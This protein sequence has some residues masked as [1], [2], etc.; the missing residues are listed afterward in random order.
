VNIE[1]RKQNPSILHRE[2]NAKSM[3]HNVAYNVYF[4]LPHNHM[5]KLNWQSELKTLQLQ[6]AEQK[7]KV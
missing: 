5:G 7:K 6:L 2:V 4:I 3:G 1:K